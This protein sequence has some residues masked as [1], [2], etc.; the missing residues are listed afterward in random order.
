MRARCPG[1]ATMISKGAAVSSG[2]HAGES[3]RKRTHRRAETAARVT[4]KRILEFFAETSCAAQSEGCRNSSTAT[5]DPRSG[6]DPGSGLAGGNVYRP[7]SREAVRPPGRQLPSNRERHYWQPREAPA[8]HTW[9]G[10]TAIQAWA[11]SERCGQPDSGPAGRRPDA[12]PAFWHALNK[13]QQQAWSCP[14]EP[15]ATTALKN[16]EF[17]FRNLLRS[18]SPRR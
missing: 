13:C 17:F 8:S 18:A 10:L 9:R 2:S 6:R 3:I 1:R 12:A 16:L 14:L 7:G 5:K 15:A 4:S 11:C